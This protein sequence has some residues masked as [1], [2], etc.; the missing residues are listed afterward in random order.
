MCSALFAELLNRVGAV[1][2]VDCF[3]QGSAFAAVWSALPP[4]EGSPSAAPIAPVLAIF[5]PF[6]AQLW[7]SLECSTD[8]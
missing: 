2:H 8:R 6:G 3:A 5:S 4:S 7:C 1:C